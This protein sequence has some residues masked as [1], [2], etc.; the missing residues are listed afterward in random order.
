MRNLLKK[1]FLRA[2]ESLSNIFLISWHVS[3]NLE[4]FFDFLCVERKEDV[5]KKIK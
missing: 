2:K 5:Y 3:L 4:R 1:T